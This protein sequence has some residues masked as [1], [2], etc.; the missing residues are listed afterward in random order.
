MSSSGYML[1]ESV[2]PNTSAINQPISPNGLCFLASILVPEAR[3]PTAGVVTSRGPTAAMTEVAAIASDA[4]LAGRSTL[5]MISAST[6]EEEI[7]DCSPIH[8]LSGTMHPQTSG[9]AM[10]GIHTKVGGT[11][12]AFTLTVVGDAVAVIV[13]YGGPISC[14]Q[15]GRE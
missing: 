9:A 8:G 13:G 5:V 3:G 14:D 15:C 10:L 11:T 12:T 6:T 1:G 4:T 7:S 2:H